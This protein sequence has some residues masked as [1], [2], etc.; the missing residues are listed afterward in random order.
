MRLPTRGGAT[1]ATVEQTPDGRRIV[2]SREVD[3]SGDVCWDCFTDTTLWPE[4]GPSITA[5]DCP[6]RYIE[7]GSTGRI[8][9]LGGLWVP[10]EITHCGEYRWTWRVGRIP[11]T[12][13]RV[14]ETSH[15]TI[16]FEVPL[17]AAGYVPVCLTALQK[18][19]RLVE[20]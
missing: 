11:A 20:Q 8:R 4:W 1:T 5:V 15:T 9:T 16:E 2:V 6:D 12:G 3:A 7:A 13:H 10:F 17:A 14:R 19:A 18:L